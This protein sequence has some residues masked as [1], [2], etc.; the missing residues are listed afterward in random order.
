[1]RIKSSAEFT[2]HSAKYVKDIMFYLLPSFSVWY[3]KDNQRPGYNLEFIELKFE[4]LFF[5]VEIII[6]RK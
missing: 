6:H 5:K 2:M 1:M 3:I 4:W